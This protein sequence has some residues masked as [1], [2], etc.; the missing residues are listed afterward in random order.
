MTSSRIAK[1]IKGLL[2]LVVI[3]SLLIWVPVLLIQSLGFSY[4]EQVGNLVDPLTS[5][6]V[7]A[8]AALRLGLS[9]LAWLAWIQIAWS[10]VVELLAAIR[11]RTANTVKALVPGAQVGARRLVAT[12]ML[13]FSLAGPMSSAASGLTP[14]P[15]QS[16]IVAPEDADSAEVVNDGD[17]DSG[18]VELGATTVQ[19]S[20]AQID[21]DEYDLVDYTVQP[22]DTFWS[23]AEESTGNGLAW[24]QIRELNVGVMSDG[25][26]LTEVTDSL[27]PGWTIKV[28]VPRSADESTQIELADA[29]ASPDT[30]VAGT[31]AAVA[32]AV[33]AAVTAGDA[34]AAA[35]SADEANEAPAGEDREAVAVDSSGVVEVEPGDHFWELAAQRLA[36]AW[37]RQPTA[38]EISPYWAD[39]VA[40]NSGRLLPPNDPDVIYPEQVFEL[41]PTPADPLAP[42]V[43]VGAMV[44]SNTEAQG[45]EAPDAET[46]GPGAPAAESNGPGAPDAEVPGGV[47][48]GLDLSVVP[49][50]EDLAE[51]PAEG[52]LSTITSMY[53]T[54]AAGDLSSRDIG[55]ASIEDFSTSRSATGDISDNARERSSEGSGGMADQAAAV[56]AALAGF[57]L[58]SAGVARIVDRRQ[59]R[60]LGARR[61]GTAPIFR[62]PQSA[63]ELFAAAADDA[64][65]TDVDLGLRHLGLATE[66]HAM[67]MPE[68]VGALIDDETI[69]F[70]MANKH[71]SAPAPFAATRGGMIW[72]LNRP[73][74]SLPDAWA[75]NPYPL[76]VSTGYTAADRLMVDLEYLQ[77]LHIDGEPNAVVDS[78]ATMALELATTP[79]ADTVEI[80]CVGFGDELAELE[81]IRVIPDL[82][83]IMERVERH[84]NAAATMA[85][86]IDLTAAGGR[87]AEVG[88]WTP[89]VVFDPFGLDRQASQRLVAA[90]NSIHGGGVSAVVTYPEDTG[91][92][93]EISG[94]KVAIPSYHIKI[95]RSTMT[96]P[97]RAEVVSAI[98]DASQPAV[99]EHPALAEELTARAANDNREAAGDSVAEIRPLQPFND[100]PDSRYTPN[101]AVVSPEVRYTVKLL[102]PLR[103]VDSTGHPILF[104]RA[105]TAEFIAYLAHNR[106]GVAV[107][108]VM[109]A[110]WPAT[111]ARRPWINNVY[112]DARRCLGGGPDGVSIVAESGAEDAYVLARTVVTDVDVF[113]DMVAQAEQ[114]DLTSASELLIEALELIDGIPYANITSRWPRH[115]GYWLQVA[116]MVDET[117]RSVASLALD[118]FDDP[119]LA[120]WATARGLLA[121]PYSVELHRLRLRAAIASASDTSVEAVF[122]HYQTVAMSDDHRPEGRSQLDPGIV[123]LFE[124]YRRTQVSELT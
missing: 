71:P 21:L 110:L 7:K 115:D 61:P 12:A 88:D 70:L 41:P 102:G 87:T 59:L 54:V 22:G 44:P 40:A 109:D 4:P 15:A 27:T 16:E 101:P 52:D 65:L 5:N 57:G 121:N 25:S 84:A 45:T 50:A 36:D 43:G 100:G 89:M 116:L 82:G 108:T 119:S 64:A 58:L 38:A 91:L 6:N 96:L 66:R 75:A 9:L 95:E 51:D 68:L 1:A 105:T 29:G 79:L 73:V 62:P 17:G 117:A 92:T 23:V 28:P 113:A 18:S 107:P 97:Q 20:A 69:R 13:L 93:M 37:G 46:Q 49:D 67:A 111:T 48:G 90:A 39:M 86:S 81:R 80:V 74:P 11:G 94:S 106:D 99:E 33:A 72:R 98:I 63:K 42:A 26:D 30:A 19:P 3:A 60:E 118:Q 120:E 112:A 77:A 122:Q 103:V 85:T 35:P 114:S 24:R 14:P 53:A 47:P 8:G 123:E 78:M 32:G 2:A 34:E 10:L 124:A 31:D 76:L 55:P 104:D 56:V 83:S